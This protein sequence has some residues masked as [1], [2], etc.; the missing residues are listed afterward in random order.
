MTSNAVD[1]VRLNTAVLAEPGRIH[2]HP[3]V[4]SLGEKDPELSFLCPLARALLLLESN[5]CTPHDALSALE[6][7]WLIDDSLIFKEK[8]WQPYDNVE[9][10]EF[11][12]YTIQAFAAGRCFEL[13]FDSEATLHFCS[14]EYKCLIVADTA[15]HLLTRKSEANAFTE[16]KLLLTWLAS[17]TQKPIGYPEGEDEPLC[18]ISHR[19]TTINGIKVNGPTMHCGGHETWLEGVSNDWSEYE[20]LEE[21]S[22]ITALT[23]ELAKKIGIGSAQ[24]SSVCASFPPAAKQPFWLSSEIDVN[25]TWLTAEQLQEGYSRGRR[26]RVEDAPIRLALGCGEEWTPTTDR[27]DEE[28]CDTEGVDYPLAHPPVLTF[29]INPASERFTDAIEEYRPYLLTLADIATNTRE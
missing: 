6:T 28:A 4:Q 20:D 19:L 3:T 26:V 11:V 23:P 25:S 27:E 29:D 24:D 2:R 1:L 16:P 21:L 12:R 22:W 14:D 18:G 13:G 10:K 15:A 7:C 8:G 9:G 17:K 5:N